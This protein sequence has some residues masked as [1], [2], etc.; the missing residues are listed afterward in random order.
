MSLLQDALQRARERTPATLISKAVEAGTKKPFSPLPQMPE[1]KARPL[2]KESQWHTPPIITQIRRQM[3]TVAP[4]LPAN[5][6]LPKQKILAAC[7]IILMG[8]LS[9]LFLLRQGLP[10]SK[11]TA[12]ALREVSKP[13]PALRM[14]SLVPEISFLPKL[15][16]TGITVSGDEKLA[17][18][19]NQVVG[20]GDFLR[21]QARVK[22]I[23]ER[24]VV[25]EFQGRELRLTL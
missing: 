8:V 13:M 9:V 1:S 22:E 24:S 3:N 2:P 12:S 10:L 5:R 17:L 15:S 11:P 4:P 16:L 7:L 25:L 14:P 20:V 6:E 21:E 23:R 19:N 18:I